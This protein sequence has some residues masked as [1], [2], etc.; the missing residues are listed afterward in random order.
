MPLLN[1]RTT[2]AR[3]EIRTYARLFQI[4]RHLAAKSAE[5][6]EGSS[7]LAAASVVF[8]AF[9]IEALI[10]HFGMQRVPNWTKRERKLGAEGRLAKLLSVLSL[11]PD[12]TSALGQVRPFSRS[13]VTSLHTA[14]P[15]FWKRPLLMMLGQRLRRRD[16]S[17][18]GRLPRT[19]EPPTSS[20]QTFA[21]S[22]VRYIAPV[23]FPKRRSRFWAALE[24]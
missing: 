7:H 3:A 23:A 2:R 10:N 4:A 13:C 21:R 17:N 5:A 9:T 1:I 20:S 14:G 16:C 22:L 19:R 12:M 11:A 15:D 8:S 6:P 18:A 24:A